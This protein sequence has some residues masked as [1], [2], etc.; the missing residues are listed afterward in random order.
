MNF[1]TGWSPDVLVDIISAG[2]A[3]RCCRWG[4]AA[5]VPARPGGEDS[6]RTTRSGPVGQI[7]RR[8]FGIPSK[9]NSLDVR[10]PK[11]VSNLENLSA[12]EAEDH[13]SI[14]LEQ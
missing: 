2:T 8:S 9:L 13:P 14:V 10:H 5:V 12:E 1:K 7:E 11:I 6:G 3:V 4:E